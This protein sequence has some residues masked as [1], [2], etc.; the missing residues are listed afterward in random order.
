MQIAHHFR[1]TCYLK[2]MSV[3]NEA[4]SS[5][6][7]NNKISI[8][9]HCRMSHLAQRLSLCSEPSR[10]IKATSRHWDCLAPA[11]Q[12]SVCWPKATEMALT[13]LSLLRGCQ[14]I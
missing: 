5:T 14:G 4:F 3:W 10:F 1:G 13:Q 7:L 11:A 2:K 6:P 12:H 8:L 9:Q